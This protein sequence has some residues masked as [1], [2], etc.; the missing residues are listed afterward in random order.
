[1]SKKE[2]VKE[3]IE[4]SLD[5]KRGALTYEIDKSQLDDYEFRI[6]PPEPGG[7][8]H[9]SELLTTFFGM[10]LSYYI[11]YDSEKDVVEIVM[12]FNEFEKR[13]KAA[14]SKAQ[15]IKEKEIESELEPAAF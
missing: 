2:I 6:F 11:R 4:N 3:L 14:K 5:Y 10:G 12:H 1:M 9:S 13:E 7:I 15:P 8:I